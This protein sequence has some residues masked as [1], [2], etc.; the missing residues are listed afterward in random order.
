MDQY[1]AKG[2]KMNW[3]GK[4]GGQQGLGVPTGKGDTFNKST[5]PTCSTLHPQIQNPFL[6]NASIQMYA[7]LNCICSFRDRISLLL[8]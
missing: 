2:N 6:Q 5:P 4:R 3:S 8:L 1:Y 7:L